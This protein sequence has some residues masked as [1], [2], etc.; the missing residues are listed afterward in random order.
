MY[1]YAWNLELGDGVNINKKVALKYYKMAAE[2]G[3]VKSMVK[4]AEMTY[5]GKGVPENKKTAI[6]YYKMAA[7]AGDVFSMFTCG[8]IFT[9]G[10]DEI[11]ESYKEAT[12]YFKMG[13][14]KGDEKCNEMYQILIEKENGTVASSKCC[15]LI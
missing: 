10:D 1:K 11:P 3:N 2:K 7:D 6:K 8:I 9:D 4:C 12:K 13:A 14:D 15:M 5:Y